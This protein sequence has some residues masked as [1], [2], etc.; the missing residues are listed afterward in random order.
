MYIYIYI[1]IYIYY[2]YYYHCETQLVTSKTFKLH[3]ILQELL[4]HFVRSTI[5]KLVRSS[6]PGV[7]WKKDVLR[8]F[9]KFTSYVI[10]V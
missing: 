8:N 7:F 5:E 3:R 10:I 2:I 4:K 6:R 9:A 1:Y